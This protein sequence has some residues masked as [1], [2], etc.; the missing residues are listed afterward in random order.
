M[1]AAQVQEGREDLL[2][3]L[4]ETKHFFIASAN[5]SA[6]INTELQIEEGLP[7][8]KGPFSLRLLSLPQSIVEQIRSGRETA[9]ISISPERMTRDLD[10]DNDDLRAQLPARSSLDLRWEDPR[11]TLK[12]I[13][14]I[15][16]LEESLACFRMLSELMGLPF[17]RDALEKTIRDALRRGKHPTLPMLG[18]LAAGMGLHASGTRVPS[19]MCT[20]MNVP[21][22]TN[23][24][25]CF[26]VIVR[27]DSDGLLIAHPRQGW[28]E[29]TPNLV[30][31]R[32]QKAW[33]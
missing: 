2:N 32:P 4:D 33:T 16:A 18:Q 8:S 17:R 19:S 27:S 12:L 21:C 23:W 10:D 24:D 14:G 31:E 9:N 1:P 15:G 7:S 3:P 22:L 25:D 29:L 28:L 11:K 20:R 6:E 13:T 26:A 5:S 30:A